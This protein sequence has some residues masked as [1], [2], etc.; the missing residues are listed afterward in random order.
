MS[1]EQ[2]K[3]EKR[4]KQVMLKQYLVSGAPP[5]A[6][7]IRKAALIVHTCPKLANEEFTRKFPDCSIR[8][9][10]LVAESNLTKEDMEGR[11]FWAENRNW[12]LIDRESDDAT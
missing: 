5:G 8:S 2:G 4:K 3:T 10:F 1:D 9:T 12:L 11:D 7:R 6:A